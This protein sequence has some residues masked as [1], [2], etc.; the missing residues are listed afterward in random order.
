MYQIKSFWAECLFANKLYEETTPNLLQCADDVW[1][2]L[3]LYHVLPKTPTYC[4]SWEEELYTCLVLKLVFNA[5]NEWGK[6]QF[7]LANSWFRVRLHNLISLIMI[8]YYWETSL[9]RFLVE[10][11]DTGLLKTEHDFE[12]ML[13]KTKWINSIQVNQISTLSP[14][15]LFIFC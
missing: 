13:I 2:M 9:V 8:S 7:L 6:V 1:L 10:C 15:I 14:F 3:F 4:L 12:I 5:I 11:D